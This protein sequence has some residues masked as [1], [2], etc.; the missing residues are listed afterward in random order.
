M[1][2]GEYDYDKHLLILRSEY[3]D[4]DENSGENLDS[5][6]CE[7][8]NGIQIVIKSNIKKDWRQTYNFPCDKKVSVETHYEGVYPLGALASCK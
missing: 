3:V 4:G 8:E 5:F 1:K 6:I 7:I 2:S